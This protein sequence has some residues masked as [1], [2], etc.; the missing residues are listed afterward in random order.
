M[1]P[2]CGAFVDS[3]HFG[4]GG[5][6]FQNVKGYESGMSKE[7]Y[8]HKSF[9]TNLVYSVNSTFVRHYALDQSGFIYCWNT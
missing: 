5:G 1:P 9:S 6:C 8:V 7:D 3:Y 2:K 4:P